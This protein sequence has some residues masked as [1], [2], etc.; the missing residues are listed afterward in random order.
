[1]GH[2]DDCHSKDDET[3]I[4]EARRKRE[5]VTTGD[6]EKVI[7]KLEKRIAELEKLLEPDDGHS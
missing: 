6:F 5:P 4:T 3:K 7:R 1:M 2:Y